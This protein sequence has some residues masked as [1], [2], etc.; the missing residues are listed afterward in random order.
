MTAVIGWVNRMGLPE[1][2]FAGVMA[3]LVGVAAVFWSTGA[4]MVAV[5][6]GSGTYSHG[7]F[8][9]PAFV[10]LVWGRRMRLA[11]LPIR[12]SW[13]ALPVVALVGPVW[14]VGQWM[15]LAM[16]SQFAMVAMVPAAIAGMFGLA[17]L[18]ALLFPLAFLF[19]AVPFGESLV[20]VLM[21]WTADFT[22]A[23]LKLTG[24]PVYRDGLH[25][26]IPSGKWSVVDSCSGIRY[27][28]ACLAVSSLYAWTIYRGNVRRI[29]FVAL[30]ALIA[31]VANWV[32]AYAIVML[33]HLSN[34]QIATGADHLVYGGLFFGVV[35]A[36]VFALGAFWRENLSPDEVQAGAAREQPP[37][38]LSGPTGR[39][40]P[41]RA[42]ATA[43]V[44]A[45]LTWPVVAIASA[46]Q[47][48]RPSIEAPA[49]RPQGGWVSLEQPLAS[50]RPVLRNPAAV[51][52]ASFA[53]G[54]KAVG[55][56]IGV[57][58]RS[59]AES[60]LTTAMNRFLEPDG[61]NPQWKLSR[62]GSA[63]ADWSGRSLDVRTGVL[64]G[65]EARLLAWQWYW[66]DGSVTAD[67]IRATVL[68]LLARLR[69]RS[70]VSAWITVYAREGDESTAAPR[71]LQEFLADTSASI[72]SALGRPALQN[73]ASS[74]K[75]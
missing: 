1:R 69:G 18:R 31:I 29:A 64:V 16:P 35:M 36:L 48:G 21:D 62:Q 26:D 51:A 38:D 40:A 63:T 34:N 15:A 58:G 52:S 70:E 53:K 59:T 6:N 28:F 60:K 20:P 75:P 2:S 55:I 56:H 11:Q 3:V 37:R 19:F 32:R 72:D 47:A 30:A 41:H 65:S 45:M 54:D 25:F 66:V 12:P 14:L 57:F 61:L 10:W 4:S 71:V 5:W 43:T 17:W 8:V 9:V 7:F 24:V 46:M 39:I 44:V 22:V 23:A 74:T 50:W 67:P 27:L 33:G 42:A 73:M 49:I 68:Q 13:W